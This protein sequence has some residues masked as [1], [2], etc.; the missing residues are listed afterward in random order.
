MDNYENN[1]W[2]LRLDDCEKAL[3]KNKFLVHRAETAEEAGH[4]VLQELLPAT[5]ARTLSWGGS[6]SVTRTGVLDAVKTDPQYEC[7]DTSDPSLSFEDKIERRRQAL[8]VDCYFTGTNALTQTGKL[9]NLDMIGNRVGALTF[10]PKHVIVIAGRNKLVADIEDALFRVKDRAAPPNAMRLDMKTPCV[11]TGFC[12][13]CNSPQRIC[14]SWTITEK[15]FPK[16]RIKV[17]LVN[18]DMG[19]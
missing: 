4:I 7:I 13:D 8:L 11:K 6:T 3:T 5:G 9:V 14:N 18:E 10:G 2:M 17:V 1:Y 19:L 15:S 16:E 12:E